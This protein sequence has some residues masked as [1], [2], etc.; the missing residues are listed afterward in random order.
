MTRGAGTVWLLCSRSGSLS[1]RLLQS[2]G[3]VSASGWLARAGLRMTQQPDA[4]SCMDLLRKYQPLAKKTRAELDGFK[5][6][7]ADKHGYLKLAAGHA[8]TC[9]VCLTGGEFH[10]KQ[11]LRYLARRS[12]KID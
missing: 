8:V 6:T 12:I 7:L 5:L 3:V 9:V 4:P 11:T 2:I 1:R 10:C